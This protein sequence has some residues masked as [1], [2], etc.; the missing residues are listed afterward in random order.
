MLRTL[1]IISTLL[2]A[3][4]EGLAQA[5]KPD[6][7]VEIV[8]GTSPGGPQDRT[9]RV[10]Q[11]ILQDQKLVP[12]PVNVVNKPG[13]GGL[14]G[15]TYVSQHPGDGHYLMLNSITLFTNHVTGR[16]TLAYTDFTPIAVVG[17][18]YV[19]VAVRSESPLKSGRDLVEQL[20]KDPGA[21][22]I[23][24]GTTF[25]NATHVS[26]VLAMKAAGVDI[27]KLKTVVF[28]SGGDAMTSL[29]GGHVDAMASA[30]STLVEQIKAGKVRMLA[31]GAPQRLGGSL[32][33]IPTW[34]ELG[35]D[36]NFELWRGLAGPRG[37]SR[38][39][40]Q[41]WDDALGKLVQTDEWKSDLA[42]YLMEN[43]YRNSAETARYWKSEHDEVK[44]VLTE[45]GIAK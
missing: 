40:I 23:S 20:K 8:V 29:L 17:V 39:Q 14:I 12:T 43:V 3:P 19:G 2:L 27:R 9:S 1:W 6:R 13:A 36:A 37:L 11:K 41:F 15:L 16:S 31:I 5:W 33:S 7:P 30:P 35:I 10:I 44:A 26:F 42:R 28:N 45:L 25:G 21:L 4:E 32:S 38:A 22:S 24:I 34:K 18:E